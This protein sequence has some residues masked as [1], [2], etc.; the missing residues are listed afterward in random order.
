MSH[1]LNGSVP[2]GSIIGWAKSL[3]GTPSLPSGFVECNG[4]T[5]SDAGS[6]LNG[7]TIP[8]LNNSGG[9]GTKRFLRGS[10]TSGTTGG[11]ETH[12]HEVTDQATC[13]DNNGDGS[14]Q[15]YV[16]T[17]DSPT[18]ATSTLPSYYEVVWII[19]VKH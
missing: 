11:S 3:T 19:R 12:T 1:L 13:A 7:A 17:V 4:Q 2:I 14:T 9:A 6:P 16:N 15:E 8:N 18:G 10:T 5:L